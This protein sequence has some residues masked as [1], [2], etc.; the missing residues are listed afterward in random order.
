[1]RDVP[2]AVLTLGLILSVLSLENIGQ[3]VMEEDFPITLTIATGESVSGQ[4]LL[5]PF[6]LLRRQVPIHPKN[7]H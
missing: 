7:A 4:N 3:R 6:G 1:M 2:T 5:I